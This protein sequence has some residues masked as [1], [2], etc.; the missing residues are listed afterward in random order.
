MMKT[1]PK[2][3]AA[4]RVR[5]KTTGSVKRRWAGR[6]MASYMRDRNLGSGS[7]LAALAREES[8]FARRDRM[9]G[10]LVSLMVRTT[11]EKMAP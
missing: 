11:M 2:Q 5:K 1:R 4:Q 6:A 8:V 10:P 7:S 3:K 9:M